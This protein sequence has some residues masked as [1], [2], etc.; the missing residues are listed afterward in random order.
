M[1]EALS[2]ISTTSGRKAL[3]LL[4]HLALQLGYSMRRRNTSIR[5]RFLPNTPQLVHALKS[6]SSLA[7]L[8]VSQLCTMRSKR[9]G[10]SSG[11]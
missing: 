8:A 4:A 11:G 10:N 2:S 9:S 1:P 7:L 5:Y 3:V 6:L